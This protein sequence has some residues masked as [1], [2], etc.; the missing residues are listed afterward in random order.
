MIYLNNR[1]RLKFLHTTLNTIHVTTIL[2]AY[3][4]QHAFDE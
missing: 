2:R 4:N 1:E 3:V